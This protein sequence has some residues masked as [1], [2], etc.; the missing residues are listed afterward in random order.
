MPSHLQAH[1]T[2]P[3]AD[4]RRGPW[5]PLLCGAESERA[6]ET[7]LAVA[8]QLRTLAEPGNG[9]TGSTPAN[10]VDHSF[11][12]AGGAAGIAILFAYLSR[13]RESEVD[14]ALAANLLDRAIAA[15]A[16]IPTEA[17]L[18]S[19]LAGVGW[20][21]AHLRGR[22]L[23]A[24]GEEINQE[25]DE[26]LLDHLAPSPWRSDYDLIS[27]LVGFG[28]YA[29]ER[30]PRPTAVTCLER[31]VERLAETAEHRPEGIT[32]HTDPAWLLDETREKFP[33]GYY[34]T[35]LAHGVP[36]VVAMLACACAVGVAEDLARPLLD[37]AVRWLLAQQL[38]GGF[39][40]WVTPDTTGEPT[41]LAWCYGDPGVAASLLWAARRVREPAWESAALAIARRAAERPAEKSGVLDAGLCHG[42]A[43][44]G[45]IF[46]R[47]YQATGEAKFAHAARF[48]FQRT[49]QMRQPKRGIA[50][51]AA[52]MP[53]L[54]G[55][56][57]GWIDD[58]GILTGAAGIALALL[59]ATTNIEPEW[60]RMLLV[61]IPP[62]SSRG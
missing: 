44:L 30:L 51:Y 14:E 1:P 55:Q 18:Y 5:Q 25:I 33:K 11:S 47:V 31:V 59:A 56:Q 46:N 42:A 53:S 21:T 40:S 19:G 49:L 37:G 52:W 26:V 48:W 4:R 15:A 7:V 6:M 29:L 20:A 45:H 41:R 32:W 54:P 9:Q 28:V 62:A 57:G 43:G 58:P 8:D 22:L 38:P 13:I 24:D 23:P 61:S 12:L 35:G 3:F 27:G 2:R 16:D 50:G 36:G 34:N 17:A 39:P 60:D 10:A